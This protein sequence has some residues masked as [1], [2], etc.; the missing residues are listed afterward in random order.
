M[1]H[2]VVK[3]LPNCVI[4]GNVIDIL[5]DGQ[6][7]WRYGYDNNGNINKISERDTRRLL[8]YDV[9]DRLKKSGSLDVQHLHRKIAKFHQNCYLQ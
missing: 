7:T 6:S 5:L 8:E 2:V 4:N 1:L 3:F 9:G